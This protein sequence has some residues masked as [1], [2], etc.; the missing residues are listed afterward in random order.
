MANFGIKVT[1]KNKNYTDTL[2]PTDLMVYSKYPQW[3]VDV[4]SSQ[5]VRYGNLQHTFKT[6]PPAGNTIEIYK[7]RHGYNYVPSHFTQ[8]ILI[9]IN[10]GD[11]II[12]STGGAD[13][14]FNNGYYNI[15]TNNEF[16]I[17]EFV[18]SPFVSSSI[19]GLG[20][21]IQFAVYAEDI[22]SDYVA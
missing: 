14:G 8:C 4:R 6:V 1:D 20:V 3:K 5:I 7:F 16:F 17:V 15:Y 11:Y 18:V 22:E 9:G 12:S 21:N 2:L 13:L 10:Y 19:I